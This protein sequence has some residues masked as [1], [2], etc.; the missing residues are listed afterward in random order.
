MTLFHW[1]LNYNLTGDCKSTCY[2]QVVPF[3]QIKGSGAAQI[4]FSV[5]FC[6]DSREKEE[7]KEETLETQQL[8]K[9][10][11]ALSQWNRNTD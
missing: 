6:V 4:R 3:S 10:G 1:L 5:S 7:G 11:V 8:A 2:S 9:Q